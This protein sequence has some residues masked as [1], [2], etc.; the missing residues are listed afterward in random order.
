MKRIILAM[1]AIAALGLSGCAYSTGVYY[2][3][4]DCH[5]HFF[6]HV[7]HYHYVPCY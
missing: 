5:P 4:Y 2:E 6:H 1:A 7:H 3:S